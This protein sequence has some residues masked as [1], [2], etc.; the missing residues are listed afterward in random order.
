[1]KR[2]DPKG[3]L[4]GFAAYDEAV[5]REGLVQLAAA[6]TR[7]SDRTVRGSKRQKV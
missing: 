1:L 4:L 6:L 7:R 3:V 2:P 5:I